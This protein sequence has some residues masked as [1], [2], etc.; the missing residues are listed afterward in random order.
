MAVAY[1]QITLTD[2]LC[3]SLKQGQTLLLLN[4]PYK[5]IKKILITIA[6]NFIKTSIGELSIWEVCHCYRK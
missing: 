2:L 1:F 6:I 5:M 4:T 3:Q